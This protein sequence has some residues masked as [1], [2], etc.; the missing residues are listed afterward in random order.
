MRAKS[1][2]E[3]IVREKSTEKK[4]GER[5]RIL[6]TVDEGSMDESSWVIT[7][8]LHSLLCG[9]QGLLELKNTHRPRVLR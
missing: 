1:Q 9:L 5:S 8:F 2:R 7:K 3:P 6:P 4:V